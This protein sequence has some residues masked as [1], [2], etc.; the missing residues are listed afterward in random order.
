MAVPIRTEPAAAQGVLA[1]IAPMVGAVAL[2]AATYA[3]SS[4]GGGIALVGGLFAV[5]G[6]IFV[7]RRPAIAILIYLTTFLF[8]YPDFLRGSGNFTINNLL[9]LTLVLLML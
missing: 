4:V 6:G 7:I 1:K 2:V 9:G 3:L 8:T 5:I